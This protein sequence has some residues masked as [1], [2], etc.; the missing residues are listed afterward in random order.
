MKIAFLFTC[1]FFMFFSSV[2]AEKDFEKEM[3]ERLVRLET[4]VNNNNL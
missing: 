2:K 1:I 4:K 3:I